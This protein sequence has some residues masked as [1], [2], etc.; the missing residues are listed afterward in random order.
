MAAVAEDGRV[1]GDLEQVHPQGLFAG[2]VATEGRVP[3]RLRVVWESGE[4]AE[5][6]DPYRFGPVLGETDLYLFGEGSHTSLS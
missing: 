1:L 5:M 2:P 3:Y 4:E 6:E